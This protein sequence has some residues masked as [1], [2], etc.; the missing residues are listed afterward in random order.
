MP[1]TG[2]GDTLNCKSNL[3]V[4]AMAGKLICGKSRGR[5]ASSKSSVGCLRVW[6]ESFERIL[7]VC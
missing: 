2:A 7:L 6:W 5:G 4:L 3:G 1:C